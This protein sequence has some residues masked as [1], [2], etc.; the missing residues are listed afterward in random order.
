MGILAHYT[1]VARHL[2]P[3]E[4]AKV[5]ARRAANLVQRKLW[6]RREWTGN[7][8][9]EF[10]RCSDRDA[11][12]WL[13][14]EGGVYAW[15]DASRRDGVR[16]LLDGMSGLR[17]R[18]LARAQRSA[19]RTFIVFGREISFGPSPIDWSLDPSTGRRWSAVPSRALRLSGNGA[20]PKYPWVLGRLD[21]LVALGQ[22]YWAAND[23]DARGRFAR[24]F[25]EQT[26]DFLLMNPPGVGIQWASPMEVALRACNLA[27]SLRMFR[28]VRAVR[29]PSFALEVLAALEAHAEFVEHHLEHHIVSNNH[30]VA[31]HVGLFVVSAL[32][33]ALPG[34]ARRLATSRENLAELIAEQ[35]HEDGFSF[36][37][38]VGYHRLAVELFSLPYL[39]GQQ[40]G[41]DLGER[42]AERLWRM[43]CVADAYCS[44][45][46]LAPQIGD[47]DSGRVWPMR[48]R[49]SLDHG[50]L[51]PFGAALFGDANL[52][53]PGA[54]LP[55][56]AVW[57][58]G[59]RGAGRF[60]RLAE[61]S[62]PVSFSSPGGL[63]VLRCP[64]AVV[65][66]SAGLSG[67]RGVGGHSHNDKLSFELHVLG[68]PVVVDPGSYTYGRDEALRTAFR[69][70]AAHNTVEVDGEEQTPI[71]P[72]RP[73]A[74]PDQTGCRVVDVRLGRDPQ[75]LVAHHS[76]Y[77]RLPSPVEHERTLLLHGKEGALCV[78]DKLSGGGTHRIVSRLHLRD[79]QVRL[80]PATPEELARAALLRG[81]LEALEPTAAEIG[82]MLA[83][84]AVVLFSKGSQVELQPSAYSSG[85]GQ[86]VPASCIVAHLPPELP[87]VAGFVVL[88]ND[89]PRR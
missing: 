30:L 71:D 35:V 75:R 63:H 47:N 34:S 41:I 1:T 9:L 88:F 22:G 52:K 58:L 10:L 69:S 19:E 83:P 29:R 42:Y 37:G 4:L 44:E 31:N 80:R 25:V 84:V 46:G 86:L 73:F 64:G 5:A 89:W 49:E 51:G 7:R 26:V 40:L 20:D 39:L 24:Q 70:T 66:V 14:D 85:Y 72:S 56:E 8:L 16:V 77:A 60:H 6:R 62:G 17:E 36:E 18:A 82:P 68:A 67:Q 2:G 21:Q 3:G 11:I 45:R 57:L 33:P 81:A 48:D 43:F 50:Y 78:L 55:D 59:P 32:F 65:A 53:R 28:D 13:L 79:E 76:G 61:L 74:L 27:A 23:D 54:E 38:S 15:C 12:E 87:L